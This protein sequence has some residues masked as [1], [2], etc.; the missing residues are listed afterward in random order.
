MEE[1]KQEQRPQY[2]YFNDDGK[3][4]VESNKGVWVDGEQY[5]KMYG[6]FTCNARTMGMIIHQFKGIAV[7]VGELKYVNKEDADDYGFGI[8]Y[9]DKFVK[10]QTRCILGAN[11]ERVEEYERELAK[12]HYTNTSIIAAQQKVDSCQ[13]AIETH[14]RAYNHLRDKVI[15]FNALPWYKRIFKK[16]EIKTN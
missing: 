14:K 10:S 3:L 16:I 12:E 9:A 7:E 13:S 1:K 6:N 15:S 4:V 8:I 5:V 2:F 11:K